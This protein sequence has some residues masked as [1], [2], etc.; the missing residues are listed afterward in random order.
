MQRMKTYAAAVGVIDRGGQQMIDVD[1]HCRQKNRQRQLPVFLKKNNRDYGRHKKV[2]NQMND[3]YSPLTE[4]I[5]S[6]YST[7]TWQMPAG[8]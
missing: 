4:E 2:Q 6:L 3:R 7:P 1:N 5:R 8:R